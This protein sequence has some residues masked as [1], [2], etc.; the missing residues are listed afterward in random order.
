MILL[1]S[2]FIIIIFL[3]AYNYL[4]GFLSP[5]V[6]ISGMFFIGAISFLLYSNYWNTDLS[7]STFSVLC[8]GIF[9]FFIGE[10]LATLF[11]F[12]RINCSFVRPQAE[13]LNE[14]FLT[15]KHYYIDSRNYFF[16]LSISI[17]ALV[18]HYKYTLQLSIAA[19]NTSSD[20][21]RMINMA[22][23]AKYN[24][25][26]IPHEPFYTTIGLVIGHCFA[27]YCLFILC[28]TSI[29][30]TW[31]FAS[32]IYIIPVIIYILQIML[33]GGRTSFLRIIIFTMLCYIYLYQRCSINRSQQWKVFI[34]VIVLIVVFF[35]VY[36]F[37]GVLRGSLN[38]DLYSLLSYPGSTIQA[39]NVYL[40]KPSYST[41]FGEETLI[42]IR[43]ILSR[44]GLTN[45]TRNVELS[46]VYWE[47][48][49][50]N[51]YTAFRRYIADYKPVGCM[52]ILLILGVFYGSLKSNLKRSNRIT[53]L[54]F[55]S[56][57]SYPVIE[58]LFEERFFI[59]IISAGTV[60]YIVVILMMRNLVK[61]K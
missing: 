17:L 2:V 20:F 12:K 13:L 14:E 50:T 61:C 43:H 25:D 40:D 59:S 30:K 21:S 38:T 36:R 55:Y 24:L 54:I 41:V 34:K 32:I 3:F 5:T 28:L 26:N 60:Y 11:H 49:A 51:I 37:Y 35:L 31:S 8:V 9:L 4:D 44:F 19:G 23:Y 39:L 42:T 16:L 22:Y 56:Y 15:E 58:F 48:G 6:Q 10:V 29:R 18:L 1:F 7:I 45:Y 52:I 57:L 53:S 27:L 46:S 33:N 47:N